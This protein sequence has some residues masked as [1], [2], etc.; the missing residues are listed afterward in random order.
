VAWREAAP[1]EAA[2]CLPRM[3]LL[4]VC[5]ERL[6]LVCLQ[7]CSWPGERLLLVRL[8]LVCLEWGCSLSASRGCSLSASNGVAEATQQ[9]RGHGRSCL[10][11]TLPLLLCLFCCV[12]SRLLAPRDSLAPASS[13]A[14]RLEWSITLITSN[15]AYQSKVPATDY[16]GKVPVRARS[17]ARPQAAGSCCNSGAAAANLP[18]RG[19]G[20]CSG[21]GTSIAAGVEGE[22]WSWPGQ[23]ERACRLHDQCWPLAGL[24]TMLAA[25]SWTNAGR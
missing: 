17:T 10:F 15:I 20:C 7:G 2:P 22:G 13:A 1:C 16:P 14:R 11:S 12:S 21:G 6:L 19:R 18:P 8:L 9:V 25:S 5:L 24:Q 3:G 23:Q 4:L